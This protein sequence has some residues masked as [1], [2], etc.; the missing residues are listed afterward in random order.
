MKRLKLLFLI[1][2]FSFSRMSYSQDFLSLLEEATKSVDTLYI[3][4]S[5]GVMKATFYDNTPRHTEYFKNFARKHY[6]DNTMFT[7]VV[8]DF[9]IQG[10]SLDSRNAAK[11]ARIGAGSRL[12]L[13]MPEFNKNNIAVCGAI[14]CPR[15]IGKMNKL[16]KSDASQFFI[17]KGRKYTSGEL[18]TIE[19]K[20][21]IPLKNAWWAK[22]Y[23][24][25]EA[26]MEKLKIENPQEY[27]KKIKKLFEDMHNMILQSDEGLVFTQ[28]QREILTTKGGALDLDNEFTFFGHL[29][30]GFK[31]LDKISNLKTDARERPY[32]D[33]KMKIRLKSAN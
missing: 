15:E 11:G 30:S 14:G 2:L 18:D 8:K 22:N 9:I 13:L 16:K 28:E 24:P 3:Y 4:T 29:V 21:N 12:H 26:E 17:V 20:H 10:G 19:M 23:T 33:V 1:F 7:R 25:H 31:V 6:F 32:R 5:L 27:K